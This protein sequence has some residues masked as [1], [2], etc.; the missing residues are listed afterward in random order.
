MEYLVIDLRHNLVQRKMNEM[1]KIENLD[2]EADI[3]LILVA[4]GKIFEL[5]FLINRLDDLIEYF[6]KTQGICF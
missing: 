1:K 2:K 5:D 6:N 4:S 3:T